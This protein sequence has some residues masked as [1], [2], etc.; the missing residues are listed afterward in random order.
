MYWSKLWI[1]FKFCYF[2][3]ITIY[4]FYLLYDK[5]WMPSILGGS[6]DISKCFLG[7]S[8]PLV[9]LDPGIKPY[10]MV[11]LAYHGHS[12]LFQFRMTHRADFVEMVLHHVITLFLIS[13]S[14]LNNF[15]RIGTLVFLTHDFSDLFGYA[16]KCLVD[17]NASGLVLT[18]YGGLLLSWGFCRLFVFPAYII[19]TGLYIADNSWDGYWIL[20]CM[21]IVLLCLHAYWFI[22][23]L[24]MGFTF[25]SKGVAEDIVDKT[26]SEKKTEE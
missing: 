17:T 14:Y 5:E 11:Q 9:E 20:N 4:G 19:N 13:F 25:A 3:F 2:L 10:Y 7:L 21:M 6:G 8:Y 15:T 22:L 24:K 16:T 12:F 26:K 1:M 18:A 23:F